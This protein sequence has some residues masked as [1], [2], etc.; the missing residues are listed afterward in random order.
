MVWILAI[1]ATV[2]ELVWNEVALILWPLDFALFWPATRWLRGKLWAGPLL[3]RYLDIR[4]LGLLLVAIG[5]GVGLLEQRPFV[6]LVMALSLVGGLRLALHSV[7]S[8]PP[9]S[10]PPPPR[11]SGKKKRKG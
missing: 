4:L 8:R 6:W 2:P 11:R 9:P 1:I 7:P 5:H 10:T 3:R